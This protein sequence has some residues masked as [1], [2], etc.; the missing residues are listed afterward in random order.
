MSSTHERHG[1]RPRVYLAGPEVFLPNAMEIGMQKKDLCA[2]HGFEGVFPMDLSPTGTGSPSDAGHEIVDI[3]M[4]M[5]EGCQLCVANLTPFRGVSMDVG[6]AVEIGFMVSSGKPVF[7]YT[8]STD[9]YNV[10]LEQS[11]WRDDTM[12]EDFGFFD[13]AMCE[14]VIVRSGGVVIR[15]ATE[16][17][18]LLTELDG[19]EECLSLAA[20]WWQLSGH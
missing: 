10:R 4:A 5:M 1:I 18:K 11:G 8:N 16:P 2:H 15:Q 7:G 13:N 17:A 14:G 6:T 20:R 19:F 12:V 9:D 3:C